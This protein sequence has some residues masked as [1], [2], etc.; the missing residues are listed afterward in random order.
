MQITTNCI[1]KIAGIN[2]NTV[3]WKSSSAITQAQENS[4]DSEQKREIVDCR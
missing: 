4:N 1:R 3:T 2:F